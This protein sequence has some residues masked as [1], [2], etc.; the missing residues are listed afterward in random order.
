MCYSLDN[1][2]LNIFFLLFSFLKKQ[3]KKRTLILFTTYNTQLLSL[4]QG[5]LHFLLLQVLKHFNNSQQCSP[6]QY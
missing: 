3:T 2:S 6:H 4:T 1:L 5:L